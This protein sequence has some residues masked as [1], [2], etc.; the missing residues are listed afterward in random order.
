MLDFAA[1]DDALGVIV[2]VNALIRPAGRK[3][4]SRY[5]S[6]L[7]ARAQLD[8]RRQPITFWRPNQ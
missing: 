3:E 5:R 2:V 6:Y 1:L 7:P 8:S 4:R